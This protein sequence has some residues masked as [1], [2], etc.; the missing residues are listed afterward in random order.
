MAVLDQ[1]RLRPGHALDNDE[2]LR[3]G[4]EI[5]IEIQCARIRKTEYLERIGA[6]IGKDA[7]GDGRGQVRADEV[8]VQICRRADA[9]GDGSE[10]LVPLQ[11]ERRTDANRDR[12]Q[13]RRRDSRARVEIVQKAAQ[14]PRQASLDKWAF[15]RSCTVVTS[16]GEIWHTRRRGGVDG[17]R[18]D[19]VHE[20]RLAE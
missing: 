8:E 2:E 16:R 17:L 12:D 4:Y 10:R 20:K 11:A 18:D 15:I 3:V 6:D 14:R 9:H 19:A 1:V 7:D 13:L 5:I